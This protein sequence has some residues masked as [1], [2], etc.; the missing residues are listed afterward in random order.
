MCIIVY[1][2]S[3]ISVPYQTLETC[4]DNNPDGAGF[5]YPRNGHLVIKKGF[6]DFE[7]FMKNY[8]SLEDRDSLPVVIHF[9][10]TTHGITAPKNTH[11]FYIRNNVLGFAHNGTIPGVSTNKVLSDTQMFNRQILQKLPVDFLSNT[12]TMKLIEDFVGWSRLVFM[13]N[14]GAVTVVG[15]EC[16][17]EDELGIWYSNDGWR[18]DVWSRYLP[19][20]EK[21]YS[22]Y[23]DY[24]CMECECFTT[25]EQLWEQVGVKLCP[26]CGSDKVLPWED[27]DIMQQTKEEEEV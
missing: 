20:N 12:A 15:W 5:M 17:E 16:G 19:S 11:P 27:F 4:W 10:I 25:E 23:A 6:M 2:P 24:I 26:E 22:C 7:L 13:D 1:K 8:L 18:K 21:V 3:G 9:R 14:L